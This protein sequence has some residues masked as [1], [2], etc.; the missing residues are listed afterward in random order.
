MIWLHITSLSLSFS[1]IHLHWLTCCS[2]NDWPDELLLWA[3]V[4]FL[5]WAAFPLYGSVPHFFSGPHS[6]S[7]THCGFSRSPC[8]KLQSSRSHNSFYSLFC[9]FLPLF[10]S[11]FFLEI[12]TQFLTRQQNTLN[13]APMSPKRGSAIC[14]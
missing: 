2:L 14:G 13:K 11:D 10:L 5:E 9:C 1:L 6:I 7:A 12:S 4:C 8:L 3:S